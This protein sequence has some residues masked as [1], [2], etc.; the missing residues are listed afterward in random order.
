[1]RKGVLPILQNIHRNIGIIDLQH[2]SPCEPNIFFCLTRI[3]DKIG[4]G[5]V[6]A[7]GLKGGQVDLFETQCG[8]AQPFDDLISQI[9]D[10]SI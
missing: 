2:C 4:I 1:M 6:F 9:R 3:G 8:F 5:F 7:Y 10:E